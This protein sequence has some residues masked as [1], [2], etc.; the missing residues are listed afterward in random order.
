MKLLILYT[1]K[2]S[3]V[4][5]YKIYSKFAAIGAVYGQKSGSS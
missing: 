5:K 1:V 4:I 3:C 2:K